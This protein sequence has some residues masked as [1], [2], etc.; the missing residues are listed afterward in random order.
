[1]PRWPSSSVSLTTGTRCALRCPLIVFAW[2]SYARFEGASRHDRF[3][4]EA[5]EASLASFAPSEGQETFGS[6]VTTVTKSAS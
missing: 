5:L 4:C 6:D 1:M 2:L 3:I